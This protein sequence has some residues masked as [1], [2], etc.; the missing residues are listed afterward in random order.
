[1]EEL[2]GITKRSGLIA[3]RIAVVEAVVRE[4]AETWKGHLFR[5]HALERLMDNRGMP[6]LEG[7]AFDS[8]LVWK[9]VGAD[10]CRIGR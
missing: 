4:Q 3:A 9:S 2:H 5:G 10:L 8:E 7:A 1:M 6:L